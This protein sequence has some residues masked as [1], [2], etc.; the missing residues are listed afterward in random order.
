M[1]KQIEALKHHAYA[2]A[3][4]VNILRVRIDTHTVDRNRAGVVGLEAV[5]TAQHRRFA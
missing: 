2:H 5:D 1:C 4:C 3:Q